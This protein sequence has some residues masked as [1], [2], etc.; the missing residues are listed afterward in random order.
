MIQFENFHT[1]DGKTV[2]VAVG[3]DPEPLHKVL[4]AGGPLQS[5][6]WWTCPVCG[7]ERPAGQ[8]RVC[9]TP[10]CRAGICPVTGE[11]D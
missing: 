4:P 8:P 2:T 9:L 3:H 5:R 11:R 1:L 10:S 6:E 7:V